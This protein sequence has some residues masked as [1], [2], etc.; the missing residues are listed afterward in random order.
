MQHPDPAQALGGPAFLWG[1]AF[2]N[3]VAGVPIDKHHEYTGSLRLPADSYTVVDAG[4]PGDWAYFATSLAGLGAK[5]ADVDAA[6]AA[7][8]IAKRFCAKPHEVERVIAAIENPGDH[9]SEIALLKSQI[10]DGVSRYLFEQTKRRPMVFP[11]V[12]EV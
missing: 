4:T 9:I 5:L 6:G 12:V 3:I 10:K 1:V 11:V 8:E 2:A 7:A